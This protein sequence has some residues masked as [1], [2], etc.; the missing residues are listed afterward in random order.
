MF[1]DGKLKG[2][3]HINAIVPGHLL[4][5]TDI[6]HWRYLVCGLFSFSA[7]F[8]SSGDRSV[9][10]WTIWQSHLLLGREEDPALLQPAA[11]LLGLPFGRGRFPHFRCGLSSVSLAGGGHCHWAACQHQH[12]DASV[13]FF[14]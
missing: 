10:L 9:S 5:L 4:H 14:G 6:S 11:V 7:Q 1:V 8:F 13:Y 12:H 3:E 2:Q